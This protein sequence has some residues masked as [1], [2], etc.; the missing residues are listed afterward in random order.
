M[1]PIDRTVLETRSTRSLLSAYAVSQFG[2]WLFRTGVVFY[3]YNQNNGSTAVLTTAIVVV[4]LPVLFGSRLL[5]PLADRLDTRRALIGLDVLRALVLAVLLVLVLAG[6]GATAV[7]TIGVMGFLSLLTPFFIASQTAYLR[8]ILDRDRLPS[9]LA[10]V[11]R[12]E[13]LMFVL[14]TATAPVMLYLTDLPTLILLDIATF[15]V[16]GL[17]LVRLMPAPV[18]PAEDT[19]GEAAGGPRLS[20]ASRLLLVCVV[21]LNLGAGLI[22]VYPN[23]VARDFL[24]G[25]ATWLSV[26]NLANGIGGVAGAVLVGRLLRVRGLR[27]GVVAAGVVAVSLVGMAFVTT[28]WIVVL[29]SSLMLLAGQV[30]AVTLQSRILANEPVRVAGRVSGQFTLAT[31]AGVTGSTLLFLGVTSLGDLRVSFTVLLV[32]GAALAGVSTVIGAVALRRF[33]DHAP[34]EPPVALSRAGSTS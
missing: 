21:V 24:G 23:V 31:F 16:S 34:E 3:A 1:T 10:A 14:G 19:G 12:V 33:G 32:L 7:A 25:A 15:V 29:S 11:T 28:A 8:R 4:Y 17:L 18:P 26:I 27:P 20:P 6:I 30:F 22:N 5:A 9:M 13:W 2:N